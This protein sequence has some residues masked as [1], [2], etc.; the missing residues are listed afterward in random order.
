[1]IDLLEHKRAARIVALLAAAAVTLAIYASGLH[2]P[3]LLDDAPN[4]ETIQRWVEGR[5][6]WRSAIDNRSGPMG[7]SVSMLTF[8]LDAARRQA[9]DAEAFKTTNLVIHIICGMLVYLLCRQVFRRITATRDIASTTALFVAAW[10]LFLP[11]HVSTVLY[12]VQRMAQLG[13]LFTL[14]SLIAYMAI[15]GWMERNDSFVPRVALWVAFPLSVGIG[16]LAKENAVLAV[17]LALLIEWLC[18]PPAPGRSRPRAVSWLFAVTVLLPGLLA[19]GWLVTHADAIQGGYAARSFTLAERLLTEP[20]ILWSYVKTTLFPVGE[21]MGLFHD[22]YAISTG[23]LSPWTTSLA[24]LAWMGAIVLAF[25][26]RRRHPLIS[27]GIGFF[28]IGH[29]LESSII[30][31]EL[32]FEHRNYLPDLGV[33][34]A[35]LGIA[36]ALWQSHRT[37]TAGFRRIVLACPPLILAIFAAGTWI[38]SGS[39]GDADTLFELQQSYNPTS[40]RL[41]AILGAREVERGNTRGALAHIELSERFGPANERM[42]AT[43]WRIIAYCSAGQPVPESVYAE[44]EQ[45]TELPITLNA[46]RYWEQVAAS[47]EK[48]CGDAKRLAA[49]AQ[50]WIAADHRSPRDQLIWR[51]RYNLA[52]VEAVAGDLVLAEAT[53]RQAWNDS[54]RNTGIG[55][56]LFQVNATL[57]RKEACEAIL[58]DLRRQLNTGNA[59]LV[60]A[61]NIFSKAL[62]DGQIGAP[63]KRP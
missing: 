28:L 63:A 57:G 11:M 40:P 22:N 13:A 12:I 37:P 26:C 2:G 20:R 34:L 14:V 6:N 46:M 48:G 41:Q 19:T 43:L 38:Q 17:P 27:L 21:D 47:T 42:T 4:L 18:F 49:A 9:M 44:F 16:A 3:F 7:R 30:P 59:D 51:S 61:V 56:F 33:L 5:L 24:I 1:M 52:R 8:L 60:E 23:L 32:Y 39:W 55:V 53:D 36:L 29:V 35:V 62:A 25:V 10:W 50:R 45:R 15:R 54:D 58:A 31:L